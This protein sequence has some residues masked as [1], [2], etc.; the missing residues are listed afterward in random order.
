MDFR[1]VGKA[2]GHV[3][4]LR[5]SGVERTKANVVRAFRLS[6]DR[7]SEAVGG[8]ADEAAITHYRPS[9]GHGIIVL[10]HMHPFTADLSGGVR[11]I[12]DHQ[13]HPIGQRHLMHRLAPGNHFT[14][15]PALGTELQDID[16]SV[17]QRLS[18]RQDLI[19]LHIAKID[20]A[21]ERALRWHLHPS[22][23]IIHP[24][25]QLPFQ[26]L[27]FLLHEVAHAMLGQIDLRCI[28]AEG[29][30][31]LLHT[32]ALEHIAVEDLELTWRDPSLHAL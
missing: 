29:L 11:M 23:F 8:F 22:D 2:D 24:L 10:A 17:D 1:D 19:R 15:G 7:L 5:A 26:A 3:V 6:G 14:L 18:H 20:D 12:I 16:A 4:G 27:H 30:G 9:F 31:G 28:D 13:R 21:I 25:K 32:P